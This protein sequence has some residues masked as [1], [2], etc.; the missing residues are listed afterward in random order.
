MLCLR[1][2][3]T[4]GN[5]HTSIEVGD[6]S[7]A[8]VTDKPRKRT[9]GMESL[10]HPLLG[11]Q[12][13]LQLLPDRSQI[14]GFGAGPKGSGPQEPNWIMKILGPRGP[15]PQRAPVG[16][17][18]EGWG[19]PVIHIGSSPPPLQLSLKSRCHAFT[20]GSMVGGISA[21]RVGVGDTGKGTSVP[22]PY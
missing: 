15:P 16:T 17:A 5:G 20:L 4:A 3:A 2:Y 11:E 19:L 14:R 12:P 8:V 6:S 18:L 22:T 13:T 7:G 21:P 10:Q 1:C 9:P